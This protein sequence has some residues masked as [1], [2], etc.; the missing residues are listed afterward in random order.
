MISRYHDITISRRRLGPWVGVGRC[1]ELTHNDVAHI[2]LLVRSYSVLSSFLSS[3]FFLVFFFWWSR[4]HVTTRLC[5]C[6]RRSSFSCD[7]LGSVYSFIARTAPAPAP[8]VLRPRLTL[9]LRLSSLVF[10]RR[11]GG[12][13]SFLLSFS[14]PSFLLFLFDQISIRTWF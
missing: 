7:F 8:L 3:L 5:L 10:R 4:S 9:R 13:L 6:C 11:R 2:F 12:F 14:S 1:K